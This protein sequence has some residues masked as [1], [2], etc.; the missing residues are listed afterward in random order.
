MAERLPFGEIRP[1]ARPIGAY[2]Q[3]AQQNVAGAARPQMLENPSGISTIQRA[4]TPSVNS[5]NE[6]AQI[7]EALAPFSRELGQ[8]LEKGYLSYA[9]GKIEE[10][11]YAELKNQSVRAQMGLQYQQEQ[12]AANASGVVS[13]LQKVD[14]PAAQLLQEANPWRAVGRR[15]ALAQIAGAEID[16]VLLDD[17]AMNRGQVSALAPGSPDLVKRK[18]A[19]TQK[20]LT[21]YGLSETD[22]ETPVYVTPRLNEAWDSY[23]AN[24]R[25]L[26]L[27]EVGRTSAE[28]TGGAVVSLTNTAMTKGVVD[29]DNPTLRVM[30]GTPGFGR[31]LGLALTR[32]IDTGLAVLAGDDRTKAL[33]KIKANLALMTNNPVLKG[34]VEEVRFGD[35]SMA[36]DK[37]PRW[38]DAN[39]VEYLE[40]QNKGLQLRNSNYE[41]KQQSLE[42]DLDGL[43]YGKDGPGAPGVVMDSEDYRQRVQQ[44]RGSAL[45]AG[46]RDADGYIQKRYGEGR[47]TAE[48]GFG[49]TAE[50][51]AQIDDWARNLK[52]SDLSPENIAATRAQAN[53]IANQEPTAEARNK[54]RQELQSAIDKLQKQFADMPSGTYG[55]INDELKRDMGLPAIKALDPKGEAGLLLMAPGMNIAGAMAAAPE[56]LAAFAVQLENLYTREVMAGMNE[57]RQRNPGVTE[58]PASAQN[59]IVSQAIANARKGEAY[60]LI[61]QQATGK[62]PGEVGPGKVGTGPSQGTQPGPANRGVPANKASSL[63]DTTVKAYGARPVMDKPWLHRELSLL[64]AGKPASPALY[65]L[66]KRA[67]TST[68]RYMLE[69]LR[70]Y[71]QLDQD[72]SVSKFLMQKLQRDRSQNTI[73]GANF[74]GA[75]MGMVPTGYNA[76]SPGS[77]LMNLLMPPA[78]AATMPTS[79]GSYGRGY[80]SGNSWQSGPAVAASHPEAGAGYT[81][82]GAKDAHGRPVI[83][84]RGGANSLAAMARD[85][86]GQVRFSDIASAQ[87][88]RSKNSAVGGVAGSEHLGGNALDVHGRSLEWIRKHGAKYGWYVNDYDGSHGGHVEFRGGGSASA[89]RGGGGD[90]EAKA[91]GYLKRLAYLETRIRNIPNAEGSPGR[92]YFQAFPAFSQEAIA[93]S[94]GIDPRDGD[95]NRSAKATWSWIQKHRPAA[96]EAI[97]RGDYETADRILRPT[98]PSL[99]GGS[100]AQPDH[101]QRES[102]RYLRG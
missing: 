70:F 68:T 24:Q 5:P 9:K 54:R 45:G 93:A 95:Y 55:Q 62:K 35:S 57:W 47:A 71:P 86:G 2:I 4:S 91:G 84:S 88:S 15:R 43:W 20:V 69:Q 49:I 94:G 102:R 96:A 90:P 61:Y 101:V 60:A 33:E 64:N 67:G 48:A 78:A 80:G 99:P 77:W 41:Q 22:P 12:G 19:L 53:Q 13:K 46:Y 89:M 58:I 34:A 73:S 75:G 72:G 66:A 56:K 32:E 63:P 29:P 87:R 18:A 51:Q 27:E 30:P 1:G 97:R 82:P 36:M 42:N 85:S 26:Y 79:T 10:G 76:F 21:D 16:Q 7:A 40:M 6:F 100:Q 17:L 37:R 52:P 11:Y 83:L 59:V 39:P 98:W 31:A 28:A 3:A 14:P 65:D 74:R 44:F 23:T 38:L 50:Q 25:K 8:V 92:G 81:L